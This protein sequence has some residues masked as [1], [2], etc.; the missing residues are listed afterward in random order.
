ME[1]NTTREFCLTASSQL[2]IVL[3]TVMRADTI[4]E[5]LLIVIANSPD[6]VDHKKRLPD[7]NSSLEMLIVHLPLPLLG[8][9][10]HCSTTV[11][12]CHATEASLGWH[13]CICS[14]SDQVS[15]DSIR[16]FRD[17][18]QLLNAFIKSYM[19]SAKFS[20]TCSMTLQSY[21]TS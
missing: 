18:I 15:P 14:I 21:K 7:L 10:H 1:S 19:L 2:Q 6:T 11:S 13:L 3:P 12:Y 16:V 8:T 4:L 5:L 20:Q 17:L 9:L